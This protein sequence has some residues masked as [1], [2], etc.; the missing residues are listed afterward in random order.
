MTKDVLAGVYD[1][2]AATYG[3]V[4]YFPIYARR[5]VELADVPVDGRLLDVACGRGAVMFEV[6]RR[7]GA[8][9]SITGVDI[10]EGMVVHTGR[11]IT[12]LRLQNAQTIRM[13]AENLGFPDAIFDRVFC[14]FSLQFL[15][16]LPRALREFRR[17]LKPSGMAVVST[18][19]ADDPRWDWYDE[20]VERLEAKPSLR[21]QRLDSAE[22]LRREFEAAGFGS[23][24]VVTE[25]AEFVYADAEEWW[26]TRWSLS[27]RAYLELMS[28]ADLAEFRAEVN[29][30]LEAVR[31]ADGFHE[32]H[33]IL[34]TLA[35]TE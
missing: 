20:L 12:A 31:E 15:P 34:Y 33:E 5:L 3:A 7:L 10:A 29:R 14:A 8:G 30:R 21:S 28:P 6:A 4:G 17:V 23:V 22:R 9:A 16:D 19:G 11:Q 2:A 32:R 26:N 35:R 18:W 1:R 25:T 13:D 27:G 24:E